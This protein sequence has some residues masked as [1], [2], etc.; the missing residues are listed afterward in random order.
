MHAL[1]LARL[2]LPAALLAAASAAS[3]KP[4]TLGAETNLRAAPGTKSEVVV[5]MPRGETVEVGACDAGWCEVTFGERH[6]YAI[7]RNLGFT[8]QAADAPVAPRR[9]VARQQYPDDGY[10]EGVVYENGPPVIY[11]DGPYYAPPP[12]VYGYYGWGWGPRWGWGG[13]W[14]GW[15]G[16]RW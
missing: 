7:A 8:A 6:G 12:Y 5:L 2:A 3:A 11:E 1:R 10:D 14:G 9:R 15:H 4:F 16:R 13:G